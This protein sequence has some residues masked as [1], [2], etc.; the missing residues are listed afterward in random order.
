[1][2]LGRRL[3]PFGAAAVL[4]ATLA[5][6]APASADTLTFHASARDRDAYVF[7]ITGVVPSHVRSARIVAAGRARRLPLRRVRAAVRRGELRVPARRALAS[8][9]RKPRLVVTT[10]EP[11]PAPAPAP[12]P[13]SGRLGGFE[14]GDLS[15]F[16]LAGMNGGT[17][18]ATRERAY[19]GTTAAKVSYDGSQIP[20]AFQRVAYDVGWGT[21]SDVWY[22]AAFYIPSFDDFCWWNPIR[23]DNYPTYG[24]SGDVGGLQIGGDHRLS[25]VRSTFDTHDEHELIGG[26][27][28]P[29]GRWFWV[30]VH[31]RL[32]GVD[33]EALSEVFLDG[34]RAGSS[35]RAN[36][37]GRRVDRI[38]YGDVAIASSC[39][40]PGSVYMDRVS[41]SDGPRGPLPTS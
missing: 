10:T 17:I 27:A 33:G 30:E 12:A 8:R 14:T 15:E 32:S 41:L 16:D 31:Q 11:A 29:Q 28:I 38:H 37:L 39:S 9:R 20:N 25:L 34:V 13:P 1:M 7:E 22:G 26:I 3:V 36:S 21:G 18:A 2:T 5:A 24:G 4:A 19:E 6:A 35:T 23:W 40:R